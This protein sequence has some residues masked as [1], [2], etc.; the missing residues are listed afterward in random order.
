MPWYG[1][2]RHTENDDPF[3]RA[4][5]EKQLEEELKGGRR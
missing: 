4:A 3:V 2:A 1:R 5:I